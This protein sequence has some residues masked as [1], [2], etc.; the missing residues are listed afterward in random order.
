MEIKRKKGITTVDFGRV[1]IK[2][3]MLNKRRARYL[4]KKKYV[5]HPEQ[6]ISELF[7]ELKQR[8]ND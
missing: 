7:K 3:N 4:E 2:T 5:P 1:Q 8:K 6:I